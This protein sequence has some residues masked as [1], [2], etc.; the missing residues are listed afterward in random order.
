MK[1][2]IPSSVK[3][4]S[5]VP[6]SLNHDDI[7][8]S[9]DDGLAETNYVFVQSNNLN[10]ERV[11]SQGT[12]VI[13]ETGFGTGL[14]FIATWHHWKRNFP[15][16]AK[17]H[18][19]STERFPLCKKDLATAL[20]LC[21]ELSEFAKLLSSAYPETAIGWHRLT[22]E[23]GNIILDLLF[24]DA[25]DSYSQLKT[26][27][28]A[29]FL[30][31]FAPSKNPDMWQPELFQQIARL[32]KPG[33]TFATFTAAGVVRRGL[34]DV[35]F[36]VKK[37]K[38]FGRK[39]EMLVGTFEDDSTKHSEKPWFNLPSVQQPTHVTV[40]G[41]G[42][43]G[44]TTA[45][46][47][48][49]RGIKV[50]LIEK[51][52]AL[53]TGGSGNRQGALYAKLPVKPTPQGELH[54]SGFLHSINL[55]KQLDTDQS[56]WS[57]CG[58]IQLATHEKEEKR[59]A[60]MI[61]QGFYP[62]SLV[63]FKSAE[64]L[65][66]LAN[67]PISH[68]G[69]YFPEAGWASPVD[70]CHQLTN[71]ENIEII[72]GNV[73]S[74]SQQNSNWFLKLEDKSQLEASHVIICCA[75]Q[76]N[77][78]EQTCHLPIKTIR[79]QVSISPQLK[80]P[81]QLNTVVC[82][83]GYISPAQNGQFCFG[84]TFDLKGKNRNVLDQDHEEN[85]RNL[86][87]ALPEIHDDLA[88]E[89]DSFQGRTAFRCSTP[90]YMPIVGPAPV[91]NSY[92]DTFGQLRKDSKWRFTDAEA[93]HYPNLYVNTGHGSK[94]LIT[95]PI[96]AELLASQLCQQPLPLPKNVVDI[97]NPSRFIIKNLIKQAI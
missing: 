60:E 36:N 58:V 51:E 66:K 70:F 28:D 86:A 96:S 52:N 55:L 46:A 94:G 20:A 67:T 57:Q 64:Q 44:C 18:F 54:V 92:V 61:G 65:S 2:I 7:Y 48:A 38:G 89:I 25:T 42:L 90:D 82:G 5:G 53:A 1:K 83:K 80:H 27:V 24:G 69:L 79:G 75:E 45:Y 21:P 15:S 43:A 78:F 59:Q 62:S 41:G 32:S 39:R 85:L 56:F 37:V 17:L 73:T 76:T 68:S 34:R 47:L 49:K 81:I 22:F 8:F 97:I 4:D 16:T 23:S 30:D 3:W 74:L 77:R 10:V 40:I 31:G 6:V 33:T 63:E 95:C 72:Q 29:W 93:E 12:T 13:A 50:T 19:I 35:G 88:P 84:A 87:E 91:F 11:D 9:V 14:N 26:E 71:S